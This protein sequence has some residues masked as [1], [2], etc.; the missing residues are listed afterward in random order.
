MGTMDLV[1]PLGLAGIRCAVAAPCG[2]PVLH[3]RFVCK[4]SSWE[5]DETN[6]D[7]RVEAL[8]RFGAAQRGPTV[9]FYE[10]D[11]QLLLVSRHREK[12]AQDFR[13]VIGRPS[14]VQA[15]RW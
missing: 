7:A 13:F 1:R 2:H 15:R 12:F 10:G 3:S 4:A 14:R 6:A 11:S 5:E 8:L 9:L